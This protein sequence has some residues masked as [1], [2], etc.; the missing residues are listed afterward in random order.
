VARITQ[1]VGA[2]AVAAAVPI[3]VYFNVWQW[4]YYYPGS[5]ESG[6][7]ATFLA[8]LLGSLGLI[9]LDRRNDRAV[10]ST[11]GATEVFVPEASMTTVPKAHALN[12]PGLARSSVN[13]CCTACGVPEATAPDHPW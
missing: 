10:A 12:A 13:D 4:A 11:V 5:Y 9:G 1:I 6:F 3:Y 7:A 2:A 8:I